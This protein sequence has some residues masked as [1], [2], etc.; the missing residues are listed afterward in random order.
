VKNGFNLSTDK[1]PEEAD[2]IPETRAQV[3]NISS[4]LSR[5]IRRI[6]TREGRKLGVTPSATPRHTIP[7][8]RLLPSGP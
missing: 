7:P 4:W 6:K 5:I 1:D 2:L 3:P 8:L